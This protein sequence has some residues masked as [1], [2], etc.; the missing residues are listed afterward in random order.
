M[1]SSSMTIGR[2]PTA[3]TSSRLIPDGHPVNG[4]AQYSYASSQML[5]YKLI[6]LI[7]FEHLYSNSDLSIVYF[8]LSSTTFY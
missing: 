5:S 1:T 7:D 6:F 2:A 3:E 8:L 4:T